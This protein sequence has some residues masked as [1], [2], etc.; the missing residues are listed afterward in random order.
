MTPLLTLPEPRRTGTE[1]RCLGCNRHLTRFGH[2]NFR[3][4]RGPAASRWCIRCWGA[5]KKINRPVFDT[6]TWAGVR[7]EARA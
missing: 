6:L 1:R 4:T 3:T 7:T 2:D 5:K